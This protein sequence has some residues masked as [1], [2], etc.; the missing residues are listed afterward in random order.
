MI[1]VM[2]AIAVSVAVIAF[3]SPVPAPTASFRSCWRAA[4]TR[5]TCSRTSATRSMLA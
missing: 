4:S 5:T 2:S 3:G 1:P